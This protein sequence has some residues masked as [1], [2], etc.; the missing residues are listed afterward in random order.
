MERGRFFYWDWRSSQ[1]ASDLSDNIQQLCMLLADVQLSAEKDRW[2][3]QADSKGIFTVKSVKRLLFSEIEAAPGFIMEWCRW[4]P[5]KCNIHAWRMELNKLPTGD[6]LRRRNIGIEDISCPFC[7]SEDESVEHVCA[8]FR[9]FLLSR[10][11]ICC[12]FTRL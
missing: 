9:K 12:R 11:R 8:R 5:S 7:Y 2:S 10:L 4:V 6:A 3:W 1:A